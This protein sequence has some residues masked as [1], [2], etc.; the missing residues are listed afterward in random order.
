MRSGRGL[1]AV[2]L[3]GC[4]LTGAAAAAQQPGELELPAPVG[5]IPLISR[6]VVNPERLRTSSVPGP[7]RDREDF[8][9]LVG[10]DGQPLR[11]SLTQ[12]LELS[13]E[14]DFVIRERGPA[15]RVTALEGTVAPIIQ[16][17]AVVWQGFVPGRRLL[18][19]RIDLDPVRETPLLPLRVELVWEPDTGAAPV[20]T[21][22]L[23]PGPGRLTVRLVNQTARSG[24]LPTGDVAADA[25]A[26]SL[27]RLLEHAVSGADDQPP[28]VGR[29][30]PARLPT[31]GLG[32]RT[33]TT[34]A[35]LRVTGNVTVAGVSGVVV[36]GAGTTP[37]AA[38]D[39][40][41]L[42]G[43]LQATTELTL[44]VPTSGQLVLDLSV[45]PTLD[46]RL[47]RPPTG[48]TWI[49]WAA[50]GPDER[51]R[52]AAVDRLVD[53]AAAA[54]RADEV[55][56][57]LGHHGPGPVTTVFR[58]GLAPA[59][60]VRAPRTPLQPKAGAL[61]LAGVAVLGILANVALIWRRL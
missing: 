4:T 41:V 54:A 25:L 49:D 24:E 37:T 9:V 53:A 40:A 19:A 2:L 32:S 43:V 42:N 3:A 39:G 1:L 6:E 31:R 61:A 35:P 56:P 5:E 50:A 36:R 57:Y 45:V 48:R 51:A 7:V 30:L 58:Y 16:R 34:V 59:E 11:V 26:P 12:R 29:G 33:A 23:L 55:A 14:G 27:Q 44:Q 10:P 28:A 22:G 21:G 18:A 13:G 20:A 47:L 17:G 46:P 8:S 15:L 52:R 38:G 60:V